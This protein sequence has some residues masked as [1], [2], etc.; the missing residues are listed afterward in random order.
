MSYMSLEC[1]IEAQEVHLYYP[2][3][4]GEYPIYYV[5]AHE[6]HSAD[7]LGSLLDDEPLVLAFIYVSEW[8]D[9]LTP[10][11]ADSLFSNQ[12]DFAGNADQFVAKVD[13]VMEKVET[14]L[15]EQDILVANRHAV[16]FSLSAIFSLYLASKRPL[17][18]SVIAI[19]PS[20]WYEGIV[21]YFKET[22]MP[23]SLEA[24]YLSLGAEEANNKNERIASVE[25]RTEA[26][27]AIFSDQGIQV[28]CTKDPGDHFDQMHRRMAD[29]IRWTRGRSI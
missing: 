13:R 14:T 28:L 15:E 10:W 21:R 22:P 27:D 11:P 5:F 6:R 2:E 25:D 23:Q 12:P 29:G 9:Y 7:R 16:G 20:S 4:K 18:R 19:S 17:F 24:V 8:H 1:V 3:D 26:L